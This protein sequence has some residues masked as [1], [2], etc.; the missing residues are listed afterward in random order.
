MKKLFNKLSLVGSAFLRYGLAVFYA[1]LLSALI[2]LCCFIVAPDFLLSPVKYL[3]Q[4]F[5]AVFLPSFILP[6]QSRIACAVLLLFFEIGVCIWIIEDMRAG[7]VDSLWQEAEYLLRTPGPLPLLFG[8][9][10]AIAIHYYLAQMKKT[11]SKQ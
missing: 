7:Y 4:G 3:V 8:G 9:L 2:Y 11:G 6:R 10:I 1:F 5:V